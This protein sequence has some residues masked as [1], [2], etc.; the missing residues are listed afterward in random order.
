[1][2][3]TNIGGSSQNYMEW[4]DVYSQKGGA[5]T[6]T[7]SYLPPK[8][9]K[10]EVNDR[11]IEVEVNGEKQAPLKQLQQN[12]TEGLCTVSL[13]VRLKPGYNTI[14]MGSA[15]TWTPDIDCFTLMPSE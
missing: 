9:G 6:M 3:V 4:K 1:M 7:I 5:Y 11:R 2:L 8:A 15:Y 12:S 13:P 10:R 14:R